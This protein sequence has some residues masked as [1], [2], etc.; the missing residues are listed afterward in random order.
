MSSSA[1]PMSAIPSSGRDNK[2][3]RLS[4]Y[5]KGLGPEAK[6]TAGR[7]NNAVVAP[8]LLQ[9]LQPHGPL[10]DELAAAARLPHFQVST[11]RSAMTVIRVD[12]Q[13]AKLLERLQF[14][15]VLRAN[16]R[17]VT[18]TNSAA[19][20][21][22]LT[23]LHLARLARQLPDAKAPMRVHGLL[24]RACQP[25]WE[26]CIN[27]D[28][29]EP[30]LV[31]FQQQ[32][33]G[34][35]LIADYTNA[36]RRVTLAH[37]AG[38]RAV[39]ENPIAPLSVPNEAGGFTSDSTWRWQPRGWWYDRCL[40]LYHAGQHAQQ[41]VDAG[42]ERVRLDYDWEALNGLPLDEA[43]EQLIEPYPYMNVPN[44][45]LLA[46]AKTAL[47]QAQLACALERYRL[48]HDSYPQALSALVPA[49]LDRIPRDVMTGRDLIY[50]RLCP[51]H[52]V[53]RSVGPDGEDARKSSSADDWLWAWPTNAV[54]RVVAPGP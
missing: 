41:R 53:L 38:W 44:P 19:A 50:Q 25:L 27:H 39:A 8:M 14:L 49:Y 37:L 1:T 20:E 22:V 52:F 54:P 3:C 46:V 5:L 40:Q 45:T 30:Q 36:V 7:T 43:A 17:L 13:E 11:D 21:D 23:S 4:K 47:H 15:Y 51:D 32:L 48:A 12:G 34:F 24:A 35:D 10:L 26:G 2:R 9:R 28:W 16:A 31:A 6:L 29:T 18:G 42:A 33:A